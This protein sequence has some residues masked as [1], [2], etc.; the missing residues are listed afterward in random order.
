LNKILLTRYSNCEY[1]P[2][3][4][5]ADTMYRPLIHRISG[6]YLKRNYEK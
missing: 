4:Y 6:R 3:L 5:I 2:V 1:F